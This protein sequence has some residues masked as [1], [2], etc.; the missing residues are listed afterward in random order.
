MMRQFEHTEQTLRGENNF[1]IT[2]KCMNI[3][4]LT[5]NYHY[6]NITKSRSEIIS[7]IFLLYSLP[8]ENYLLNRKLKYNAWVDDFPFVICYLNINS[9]HF[10]L[11]K[12]NMVQNEFF[13]YFYI[14]L[15]SNYNH[16]KY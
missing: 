6:I 8:R 2:T 1:E 12:E 14:A 4:F 16:Y 7:S 11:F 5:K 13:F 9:P 15:L 3:L 10:S